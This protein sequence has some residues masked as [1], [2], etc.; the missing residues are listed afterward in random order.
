MRVQVNTL[1]L[2]DIELTMKVG[3]SLL[4]G[5]YSLDENQ[6]GS[7]FRE[8]ENRIFIVLEYSLAPMQAITPSSVHEAVY[9]ETYIAGTHYKSPDD[10]SEM[11]TL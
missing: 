5:Y 11:K 2:T 8:L 1:L 3:R 4:S 10:L 7:V 9:Y 6:H